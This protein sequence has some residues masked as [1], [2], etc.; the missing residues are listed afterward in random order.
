M[1]EIKAGD[2]VQVHLGE[3]QG[4]PDGWYLGTVF[5][6]DP[7]ANHSAFYWVELDAEV[8]ALLGFQQISVLNPRNIQ[9]VGE[10]P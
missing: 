5:R 3:K 2:R 6:I 4:V 1:D 7:Y 8:A 9:K 10:E